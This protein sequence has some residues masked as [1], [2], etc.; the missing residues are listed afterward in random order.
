MRENIELFLKGTSGIGCAKDDL[1]QVVDL[2]ESGNIPQVINGIMAVGRKSHTLADYNGP[3]LGPQESA[4]NKR[5]FTDDQLRA[6]EGII[7]LQAGSNQGASQAGQNFGL[8][9]QI[10]D[11]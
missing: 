10:T 9:R 2:F 5:T 4:E 1:F 7:G 8:G 6:S 3:T 11:K